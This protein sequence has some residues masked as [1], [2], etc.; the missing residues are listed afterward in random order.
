MELE[1][2]DRRPLDVL[3]FDVLDAGDV[4]EVILFAASTLTRVKVW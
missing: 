1:L 3:R 4:E 2:H